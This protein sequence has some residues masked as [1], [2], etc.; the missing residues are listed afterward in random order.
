MQLCFMIIIL[1]DISIIFSLLFFL[2][3]YL[4]SAELEREVV[5][6]LQVLCKWVVR[7]KR[8]RLLVHSS[9]KK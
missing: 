5:D 6:L 4:I 1:S 9:E 8:E 3:R 2:T 7:W